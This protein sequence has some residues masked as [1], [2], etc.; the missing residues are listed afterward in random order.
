MDPL[1]GAAYFEL[2][3]ANNIPVKK[4]FDLYLSEDGTYKLEPIEKPKLLLPVFLA[5][6]TLT[7]WRE[8]L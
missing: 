6:L 2:A 7:R 4:V 3:I 1:Q 5:A 8:K